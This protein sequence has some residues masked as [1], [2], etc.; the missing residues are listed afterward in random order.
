M[1]PLKARVAVGF[2]LVTIVTLAVTGYF[3]N[4]RLYAEIE[5]ISQCRSIQIK[6]TEVIAHTTD[7]ETGQRGYLLTGKLEFLDPYWQ[8]IR[9]LDGDMRSLADL[10][11]G[12]AAQSPHLRA[13]DEHLKNKL[14]ELAATIELSQSG[15]GAEALER[16]RGG[17]GRTL[18]DKIRVEVRAMAEIEEGR[19]EDLRVRHAETVRG[20]RAITVGG[21]AFGICVI[22]AMA[23][24]AVRSMSRPTAPPAPLR[25]FTAKY[26]AA[27]A[28][29][30]ALA[31]LGQMIVQFA[32]L[33]IADDATVL[34]VSGRQRMLSQQVSKVTLRL[35]IEKEDP[36][37]QRACLADLRKEIDEF[38]TAHRGLESGDADLGLPVETNPEIHRRFSAL[39]PHYD[40]ILAAAEAILAAPPAANGVPDSER[41]RP[42]VRAILLAEPSYVEGMHELVKEYE[43][44]A[45]QRVAT[46]RTTEYFVLLGLIGLLVAEGIFVFRPAVRSLTHAYAELAGV[47]GRLQAVLDAATEVAVVATDIVGRVVVFNPGAEKMFGKPAADVIGDEVTPLF[48]G[49]L[50]AGNAGPSARFADLIGG[51]LAQNPLEVE[52]LA[53]R[54][55]GS[56]FPI[57]VVTTAIRN[58]DGSIGGYL[59]LARDVTADRQAETAMRDAREVAESASRS[60]SEFLANM[61]HE[62]RTPLNS[63]IGFSNILLKNKAGNLKPADVTYLGRILE[64]GKHL[65][66]LINTILDLSKV[67]AGRMEVHREPTDVANLIRETLAQLQPQVGDKDVKLLAEVPP[68]LPPFD[69]DASKLKQ[70]LINLIGNA[71][72]FTEKGS[73]RVIVWTDPISRAVARL[74]VR[75]T[76]IGIPAEKQQDIFEAFKQVESGS[77]R[78]YGGTGLGL[79]ISRSLCELMGYK[80]SLFESETG[81]GSCFRIEI[82]PGLSSECVPPEAAPPPKPG[83]AERA[84]P[85]A[86]KGVMPPAS[87]RVRTGRLRG[88]VIDDESDARHVLSQLLEDLGMEVFAAE[89][90][91]SGLEMAHT[92]RPDVILLDLMM[93]GMNGW[94]VMTRLRADDRVRDIPVVV[95]SIV[96][97]DSRAS[98]PDAADYVDKPASKEE[99]ARVLRRAFPLPSGRILVVEDGRGLAAALA[100]AGPDVRS[101]ERGDETEV[102]RVVDEFQPDT[103]LVDVRGGGAAGAAFLAAL[104]SRPNR[105]PLPVVVV[106]DGGPGAPSGDALPSEVVLLIL[107]TDTPAAQ[108][109]REILPRILTQ[110]VTSPA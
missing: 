107:P 26:T 89:D 63:V 95:V 55:N 58:A 79:T 57:R 105:T 5:Q 12:D 70:V 53:V 49:R 48:C 6:L 98:L 88:L 46:V 38:R 67:E 61:S 91:T 37:T 84:V 25:R 24:Y 81:K 87:A 10:T 36:S 59:L 3:L 11:A 19:V 28:S 35:V 102:L 92:H 47:T 13:L 71:L 86:L 15:K 97:R 96:A 62:L 66:G 31:L 68:S 21:T 77:D 52:A 44:D 18:M 94:E 39:R 16:V 106:S 56:T 109:L 103:V 33:R 34:N 54:A 74:D 4:E 93:P 60:K 99:L 22:L 32:L 40:A 73:I 29:I 50:T 83:T 7:A 69:T 2:V 41:I 1:T 78:K 65:L 80:L 101:C 9:I 110:R 75:D 85:A 82:R 76:G 90:G 14:S 100:D 17:Y 64:N 20:I 108:V 27:L 30:A 8:A 43:R 42:H 104:Q 45:K 23:G 72:R 51:E